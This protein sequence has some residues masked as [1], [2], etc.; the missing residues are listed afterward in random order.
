MAENPPKKLRRSSNKMLLGVAGGFA[1]YF[2]ADPTLVRVIWVVLA[3]F[4]VLPAVLAYLIFA[5]LM[6]KP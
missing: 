4:G 1:D 6:P 5:L 2:N 3:I